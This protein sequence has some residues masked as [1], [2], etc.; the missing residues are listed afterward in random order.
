M[1][2]HTH[3]NGP[4]WSDVSNFLDALRKTHGIE[5][6]ISLVR[7]GQLYQ[8]GFYVIVEAGA[9]HL[10]GPGKS[11]HKTVQGQFPSYHHKTLEALAFFLLHQLDAIAGRELWQQAELELS[12]A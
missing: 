7:A 5:A 3:G 6:V 12:P 8:P 2:K 4:D 1:S 11:W 10:E 9:P